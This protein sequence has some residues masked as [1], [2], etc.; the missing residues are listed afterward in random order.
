MA[1]IMQVLRTQD[2]QRASRYGRYPRTGLGTASLAPP[3]A[4]KTLVILAISRIHQRIDLVGESSMQKDVFRYAS[5]IID[6]SRIER[7]EEVEA[8][9]E[10]T[11]SIQFDCGIH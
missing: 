11:A 6:K 2:P 5:P 4:L 10:I 7:L 8:T 9:G 1:N 3:L